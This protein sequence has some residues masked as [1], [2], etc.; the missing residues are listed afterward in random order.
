MSCVFKPQKA[1]KLKP[2]SNHNYTF[3]ET[4]R[5][6][7]FAKKDLIKYSVLRC[8]RKLD[9]FYCFADSPEQLPFYRK[10]GFVA[11]SFPIVVGLPC[12]EYTLVSSG[13]VKR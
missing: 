6:G 2:L 7:D 10:K 11:F 1:S 4:V 8:R 9:V 13:K 3:Y 5:G 12:P